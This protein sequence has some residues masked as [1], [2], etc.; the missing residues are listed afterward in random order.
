MA[1]ASLED[2]RTFRR[3]PNGVKEGTVANSN[4]D[5]E[6]ILRRLPSNGA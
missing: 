3:T 5:I 4:S 6:Q 2:A 1:R